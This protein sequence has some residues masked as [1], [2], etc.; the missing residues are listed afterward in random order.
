MPSPCALIGPNAG[1]VGRHW[2]T[3]VPPA[4]SRVA[5]A[6]PIGRPPGE[7]GLRHLDSP[8]E[9]ALDASLARALSDSGWGSSILQRLA[10][11]VASDAA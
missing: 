9:P 3:A 1:G 7:H 4:E 6:E 2:P 8:L 11:S 10:L 5:R